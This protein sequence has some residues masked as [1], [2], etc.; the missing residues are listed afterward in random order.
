MEK[1]GVG[2]NKSIKRTL[3]NKYDLNGIPLIIA[4]KDN[5]GVGGMVNQNKKHIKIKYVSLR[6]A[7]VEE[8]KLISVILSF[9]LQ[10]L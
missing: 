3:E 9:V 10:I 1:V 2:N 8:G 7:M 4:K 6:V 5:N